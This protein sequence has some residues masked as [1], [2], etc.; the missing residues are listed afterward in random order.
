ML[1]RKR[2]YKV[3]VLYKSGNSVTFRC[4]D[5][6]IIPEVRAKWEDAKPGII[7]LG[8]DEIEAVYEL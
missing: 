5:F 2:P 4:K 3:K 8:L 1:R 6:T 7:F